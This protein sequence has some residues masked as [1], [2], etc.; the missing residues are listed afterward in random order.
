MGLV[1]NN[2][3]IVPASPSQA[4]FEA[5]R[6]EDGIWSRWFLDPLYGRHY[7]SDLVADAIT[8]GYLPADGMTFVKEG[9]LRLIAVH[10]D[11]LGLNYYTRTLNRSQAV[12]RSAEPPPSVIQAP[13]DNVHWMEMDWEIYPQGLFDV[14]SWLYYE[15]KVPRIYVTENG[16]SF[17]DGPDESGGVHDQR[18][19]NYLCDHF[20]AAKKAM[21][22]G[23]PLAGYFVWSLMDN[24]EWAFGFSQRFGLIWVDFA[25]QQRILKEQRAVVP[26]ASS[27]K[28]D[29]C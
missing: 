10:T 17:S 26:R 24:F 16:C 27:Q 4:D 19:I 6:R 3:R 5:N 9:D 21:D 29:S 20:A 8:A 22:N 7:P 15:Y 14:L 13:K 23:I 18:R 12:P 25:T 11:F 1:I 28:M 2:N